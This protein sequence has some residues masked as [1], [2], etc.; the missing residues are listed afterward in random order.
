MPE[1]GKLTISAEPLIVETDNRTDLTPGRYV[2]ISVADTGVGM[3]EVTLKRA[4]EPFFSTKG[5][6]RGTGLGLS[7]V[8]G[9][10]SQLGGGL[11]ISSKLG[12]GT[13]IKLYLP[14]SEAAVPT[15]EQAVA[16]QARTR[17]GTV[18]LVDDEELV[19]MSTADMLTD[20]GYFVV[21]AQSGE[22]AL[23]LIRDG[24]HFDV[25]VTDHLM[26]GLSGTELAREV[27]SEQPNTRVLI[28]SGYAEV[29]DIAPDLPRLTKPFRQVDLAM[30]LDEL[31]VSEPLEIS[32][33]SHLT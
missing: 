8:H 4:I 33:V 20:L 5:I 17:A 25:L 26:P 10:A 24:Q 7:M 3:D 1:G 28:I 30:R 6:G 12:L 14:T 19:R 15:P 21:E 27:Q 31:Q 2:C 29:D 23:R 13:C 18:L 22:H 9:L 16:S 11:T 32:P